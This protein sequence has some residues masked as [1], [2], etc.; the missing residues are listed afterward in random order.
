MRDPHAITLAR[1]S[2]CGG[3]AGG[4]ECCALW[5]SSDPLASRNGCLVAR[6]M[7]S[8]RGKQRCLHTPMPTGRSSS[9]R[10]LLSSIRHSPA[11]APNQADLEQEGRPKPSGRPVAHAATDRQEG[12]RIKTTDAQPTARL[13]RTAGDQI[14]PPSCFGCVP[15]GRR[16][17]TLPGVVWFIVDVARAVASQRIAGGAA[18]SRQQPVKLD[19]SK[20]AGF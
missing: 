2:F 18:A 11:R 5:M 1:E 9:S 3:G 6:T 17:N 8:C 14:Q 16:A 7:R 19:A 10:C 20:G 13:V 12:E 15:G 4:G